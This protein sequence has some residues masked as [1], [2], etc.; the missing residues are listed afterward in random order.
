M[1]TP[2]D[3]EIKRRI[4][5]AICKAEHKTSGE[6]RVHVQPKCKNDP[7]KEAQKIFHRLRMHR[8]KNRNGVLIFVAWKSRQFA[9]VGDKGIHQNVGDSFWNQ[10]RDAMNRHFAQND[11]AGGIVA[12]VQSVGEKLKAHY[13]AH[14]GDKNELLNTVSEE[15]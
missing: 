2:F 14:T 1:V 6:I 8:A 9:I 12:G 3:R 15:P 4:V 11:I 7:M 13:P 5:E 10:T